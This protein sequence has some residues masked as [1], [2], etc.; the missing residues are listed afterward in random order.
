MVHNIRLFAS[1][2]TE[3]ESN[4]LGSLFEATKCQVTEEANGSFELEMDYPVWGKRYKDLIARNFIVCKSNPMSDPQ[5]FR[6]YSISRPMDG[7]VTFNAQHI[8]YDLTCHP[9]LPFTAHSCLEAMEGLKTHSL[10]KHNFEFSTDKSTV[11][12]FGFDKPV[13]LKS[14]LG[15]T[16]GSILDTYGGDYEF[17]NF[18]VILHNKRGQD[19]GVTIRYGKNLTSFQQEENISKVYTSVYP[20]W[21]GNDDDN[22]Q[23]RVELPEHLVNVDT[24]YNFTNV[25]IKDFSS[26]FQNE[27]TEEE[28][29]EQCKKYIKDNDI[30]VPE[31]DFD[32]SF[33]QLSQSQEFADR[34]LLDQI[35]LFDTVTVEFEMLLGATA[36]AKVNKTV[37]DAIADRYDTISL[38]SVK[39]SIADTVVGLD[40]DISA[41]EER[42]MSHMDAAVENA[43]RWITNGKGY[44]VA[45]KDEAGNWKEIC[46]L[47]EPS[48]EEA[49]N[50]WRWNNG[51]FGFSG[52]GYNGPYT[53]AITQDGHIV[54]DFIDT[55]SLTADIIKAGILQDATGNVFYLDLING[56]LRMN[57]EELSISGKPITESITESVEASKAYAD[58]IIE[59]YRLEDDEKLKNSIANATTQSAIFDALTNKGELQGLFMK[60]GKLYINATYLTTGILQSKD[61]TTFFLDLDNGILKMDAEALSI[62]GTPILDKMSSIVGDSMT[63]EDIV[64]ALTDEGKN[65]G[66]FIRNGHVYISGSYVSS[67]QIVVGGRN[68][69]DGSIKVVSSSNSELVRLDKDGITLA[70]SAKISWTNISGTED[71]AYVEE[72]PTKVSDLQNDVGYITDAEVP[73]APTK[74][75]QLQ[76]DMGYITNAS[77]PSDDEIVDL[78]YSNRGTIITKEY[79]G[80]LKVV[81]GS[82]SAGTVTGSAISGGTISGTTITGSTL[83]STK[84]TNQNVYTQISG[85]T[86]SMY[87]DAQYNT[88]CGTIEPAKETVLD[89]MGGGV[90]SNNEVSGIKLNPTY[91]LM[92]NV[93]GTQVARMYSSKIFFKRAVNMSSGLTVSGSKSRIVETPDY[94]KR[95]LYSYEMSS[96]MFGD[97]GESQLDENGL[98]YIDIDEIFSETVNGS[99]EY[100]VFLQKEGPGDLWV[101]QKNLTYFVVEGTPN[102]KFSWEIK[103]K[104]RDYELVRLENDNDDLDSAS[105]DEY[106]YYI[107]EDLNPDIEK[108]ISEQDDYEPEFHDPI[109]EI[110]ADI[111][112]EINQLIQVEEETIYENS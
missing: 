82:V 69:E 22:N 1:T 78:I 96:P 53:L 52:S 61:K 26:D 65:E 46:S 28:L 99:V 19:R 17:N 34:A 27:P 92:I 112:T 50:V 88:N 31:I 56:I 104:Q 66:I 35:E 58:Q 2:T 20:Y 111:E 93:T 90:L 101:K 8:S 33:F 64:N 11:A 37:Y 36:K 72:I 76:N 57:A 89:D 67:G 14:A 55:G 97:I 81:A 18:K 49:K 87:S 83:K 30:G 63:M 98:A 51:G 47:D 45:V 110:F 107:Y 44:M 23:V 3:F 109:D 74:L 43:T 95:L 102:L 39:S 73:G 15:G 21:I 29:R 60:D 48:I 10:T 13:T 9:L 12:D 68:N 6:I 106:E 40:K 62:S 32:V 105:P 91:L 38:G 24:E 94:S 5:I 100:Q 108:R 7:I 25:L 79:I 16:E 42:T 70:P 85:S 75:S 59:Q 77:I 86:I 71:V 41:S 84:G 4:G 54:A 103:M 80:T